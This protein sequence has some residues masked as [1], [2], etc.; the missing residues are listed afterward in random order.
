MNSPR[1]APAA[2]RWYLSNL[3]AEV[4]GTERE[5]MR[6]SLKRQEAVLRSILDQLPT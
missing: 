3:R 4:A 6:D 5:A 2:L 1:Y